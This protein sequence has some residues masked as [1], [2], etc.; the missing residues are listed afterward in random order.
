M[1]APLGQTAPKFA[2]RVNA[3]VSLD[4]NRLFVVAVALSI[5]P[6]WVGRYLPLVDLPQHAAQVTALRELWSGN[7]SLAE[8]FQ[9]NWFTPYLF[10][11]LLLYALSGVLPITVAVKLMVSV[12]VAAVPFLT[13]RLLRAVGADEGLKWAAIPCSFGF[14]FYWGFLN[15]VVAVPLALLFLIQ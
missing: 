7:Q 15:F 11:Y 4:N 8:I 6:L 3:T 1:N 14:A 2:S 12:S 5:I 10:G 13:G 9:V